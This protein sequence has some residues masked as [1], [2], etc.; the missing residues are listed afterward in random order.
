MFLS[1]QNSLYILH[2]NKYTFS[3]TSDWKDTFDMNK[4]ASR[5]YWSTL[6]LQSPS[7]SSDRCIQTSSSSLSQWAQPLAT[8]VNI[9]TINMNI[10]YVE[11]YTSSVPRMTLR[12]LRT[13]VCKTI[14]N[15]VTAYQ[16]Q[17]TLWTYFQDRRA[18]SP[19]RCPAVPTAV[20]TD[21]RHPVSTKTAVFFIRRSTRSC[22]QTALDV[23]P[24]LSPALAHGTTYLPMSP[25][26]HL[27][28]PS[29]N[30]WNCICFD[31]HTVA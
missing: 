23:A 11:K 30:D 28:S 24:S 8:I 18:D 12:M 2:C 1:Y 13:T 26:H 16:T 29:E 6:V 17:N 25:Q 10:I 9:S 27:C 15:N 22:C 3:L 5:S 20:H 19:W 7:P 21:R 14:E 31:S 4:L